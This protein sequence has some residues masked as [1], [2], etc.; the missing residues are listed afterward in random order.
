MS[1]F[2]FTVGNQTF[3]EGDLSAPDERVNPAAIADGLMLEVAV[4]VNGQVRHMPL[5]TPLGM[6]VIGTM[7]KAAQERGELGDP[8]G[9]GDAA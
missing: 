6:D 5:F 1:D 7:L 2:T 3:S 9:E 8:I 4:G